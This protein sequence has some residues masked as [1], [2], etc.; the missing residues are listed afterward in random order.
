[1]SASAPV[2]PGEEDIELTLSISDK[3][4]PVLDSLVILD[5]F[6]WTPYAP[7]LGTLKPTP[8]PR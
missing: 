6:V 3:S 5:G 1:L 4:D 8:A 7:P 2:R